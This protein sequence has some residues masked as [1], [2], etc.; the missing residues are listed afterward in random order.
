MHLMFLA[1]AS[2]KRQYTLKKVM[3]GQVTK[4]AHPARFSPDDKWSRHRITLRRRFGLLLTQK[5]D[6]KVQGQ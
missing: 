2:G 6:L 5:K 4:S 1:D 3:Q